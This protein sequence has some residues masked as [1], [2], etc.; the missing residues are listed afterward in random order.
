MSFPLK[1]TTFI[2]PITNFRAINRLPRYDGIYDF[3]TI[4]SIREKV[5]NYL[6]GNTKIRSSISGYPCK[7]QRSFDIYS[8]LFN[9][10]KI[11]TCFLTDEN[12]LD[13]LNELNINRK[14]SLNS[15]TRINIMAKVSSLIENRYYG[16]I[17]NF[18]YDK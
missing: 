1:C 7:S 12:E 16:H 6:K 4:D 11:G 3:N 2:K 5:N 8:P 17:I 14:C 13:Y 9:H 10:R 18:T 15:E